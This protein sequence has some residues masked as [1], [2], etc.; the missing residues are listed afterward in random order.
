MSHFTK[1]QTQ[2]NDLVCLEKAL[3]QL[4]WKFTHDAAGVTVRGWKGAAYFRG[5]FPSPLP[6]QSRA[7]LLP[8]RVTRARLGSP[9]VAE[10]REVHA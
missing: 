4:G 2:I 1:V 6:R 7:S 10:R 3:D 5:T 9:A 8:P